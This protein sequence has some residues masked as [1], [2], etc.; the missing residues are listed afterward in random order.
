MDHN[1]EL[2][3]LFLLEELKKR[4]EK[5]NNLLKTQSAMVTELEELNDRLRDVEH[6]KSG[7]LSNI[8]NEIN[9]PLTSIL[10]LSGQILN[11]SVM[12]PEKI[13]FLASLINK[14]AFSLDFQLRN[15]FS[16]AEIEAGEIDPQPSA[17]N[18]DELLQ[19]QINFF[20]FKAI[21]QGIIISYSGVTGKIFRTDGAMLQSIVMNLLANAIQFS[22][23]GQNVTVWCNIDKNELEIAVQNSGKGI[24]PKDYKHIFERFRQLESGATKTH[25]GHGLGLSIV[26]EFTDALHGKIE[27]NSEPGKLT[28]FTIKLKE[29]EKS[30]FP[31]G[32]S[33]EGEEIF[34]GNEEVL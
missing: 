31:E 3:D 6:V 13:K 30:K 14:E 27:I 25:Q 17:L 16:A 22:T 20:Q 18:I 29:F 23:V 26:R 12:D 33:T 11:G 9:N 5:K 2:S 19:N 15:I 1:E 8:K 34:F 24:D 21:Q 7:F 10:G 32:F 4:L 28:T